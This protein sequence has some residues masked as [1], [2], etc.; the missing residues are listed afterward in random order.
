MFTGSNSNVDAYLHQGGDDYEPQNIY[1]QIIKAYS[2]H[3]I[4]SYNI[5]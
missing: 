3:F 5:K 1:Y 4:I 2:Y